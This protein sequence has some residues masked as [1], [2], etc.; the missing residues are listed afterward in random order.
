MLVHGE[1]IIILALSLIP[2]PSPQVCVEHIT[3][4]PHPAGLCGTYNGNSGDD[5]S[6]GDE[7]K[8]YDENCP[9]PPDPY[10]PCDDL[11]EWG[12]EAAKEICDNLKSELFNIIPC[13]VII[14]PP[15]SRLP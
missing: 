1:H 5:T 4:I 14:I 11:G 7:F 3:H 13:G 6:N 8:E 2:K 9:A 15:P 12:H 10:H